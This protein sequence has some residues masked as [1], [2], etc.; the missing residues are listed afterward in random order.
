MRYLQAR[1]TQTEPESTEI[2]P[3]CEREKAAIEFL[4]GVRELIRDVIGEKDAQEMV[5]SAR[6]YWDML[7]EMKDFVQDAREEQAIKDGGRVCA[8]CQ[9]DFQGDEDEERGEY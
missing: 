3:M 6:E 5:S 2:C 8:A 9:L 7:L 1:T 4:C